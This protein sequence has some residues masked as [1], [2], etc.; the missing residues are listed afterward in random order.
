MT[1]TDPGGDSPEPGLGPLEV[2]SGSSILYM[3]IML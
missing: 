1:K 3:C 2:N